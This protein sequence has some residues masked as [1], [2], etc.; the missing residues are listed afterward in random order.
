MTAPLSLYTVTVGFWTRESDEEQF[1]DIEVVAPDSET[2]E[3]LA[4]EQVTSDSARVVK[5]VRV[6]DES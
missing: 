1:V 3:E 5:V 4:L 6:E 2:A